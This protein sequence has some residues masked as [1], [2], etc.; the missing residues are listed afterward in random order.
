MTSEH[1][2]VLCTCPDYPTGIKLAN[3]LVDEGLAACINLVPGITSI[4]QW[5]GERQQGTE[6]LMVIKT[7]QDR[8]MAIQNRIKGLHP[9]ELPEIISVPIHKG[10]P[11]YLQWVDDT[12]GNTE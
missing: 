3:T 4:Y 10:L 12:T 8:Y 11:Q 7:R 5:Q 6:T 9:Y 2:V 1:I